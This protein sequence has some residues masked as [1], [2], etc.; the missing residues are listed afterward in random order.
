MLRVVMKV[1]SRASEKMET[2]RFLILHIYWSFSSDI[3]AAKGLS[4][5]A[6]LSDNLPCHSHVGDIITTNSA[7][8]SF[9][10]CCFSRHSV[11]K[12]VS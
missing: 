3:M 10:L 7:F 12:K 6:Q 8:F 9:F 2:K 5:N 11:N 4:T 1:L